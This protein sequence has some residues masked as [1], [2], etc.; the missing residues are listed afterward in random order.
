M[1]IVWVWVCALLVRAQHQHDAYDVILVG[2][3]TAGSIVAANLALEFPQLRILVLEAGPPLGASVGGTFFPDFPDQVP[4]VTMFDIPGEY[5]ALAYQ[6]RGSAY[7]LKESPFTFQGMGWGGNSEFNGMWV[8]VP[9]PSEF[10]EKW[11]SFWSFDHVRPYFERIRKKTWITESFEHFDEGMLHVYQVTAGIFQ[12]MNA[13]EQS[14]FRLRRTKQNEY[15]RPTVT[16]RNGLR[17]GPVSDWLEKALAQSNN[18]EIV[19]LAKV[20]EIVWRD[21]DGQLEAVGV[22]YQKRSQIDDSTDPSVSKHYATV[23]PSKG[24][25]ILAAGALQTTRILYMSGVVNPVFSQEHIFRK[26]PE[27][28]PEK[29]LNLRGFGVVFDHIGTSIVLTNSAVKSFYASKYGQNSKELKQY[30]TFV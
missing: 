29:R 9:L 16:A 5:S 26:C 19:S 8:Q 22:L 6:G 10:T 17:A 1:R 3:G 28:K 11:P 12:K 15:M 18:L 20:Q 21:V 30:G 4:N 2:L 23:F 25:I 14:A 27:L 24:R 13:T 7:K